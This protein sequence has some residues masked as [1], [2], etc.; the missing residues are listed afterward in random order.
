[1]PE[2]KIRGKTI[3]VTGAGGGLG[4]ALCQQLV[5]AGAQVVALDL[6]P[7][8]LQSLAN[9]VPEN[10]LTIQCDITDE[11]QCREATE[12]AGPV[13]ILINNAGI[14]HFSRFQDM[15]SATVRKVMG[16]NF[17]GA[18]NMTH[19]V[20]P[21]I[22]ERKGTIVAISSVAGF[23][24]LYGRSGYSASK[25][26]LHGF[27]DSLRSEVSEAGVEV[28]LVCPSFIASQQSNTSKAGE[29]ARPGSA[30]QTAGK[31]LDP[32][33]VAGVIVSGLTT[34]KRL[35][36]IGRISKLAWWV[37][38]MFPGIYEHLMRKKMKSEF[39]VT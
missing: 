37:H 18:V 31:P 27:F 35:L 39:G 25:H 16:V 2:S 30:S 11:D 33:V 20:L 17:F 10:L 24:P 19:A 1:M 22:I 34:H 15:E 28:M 26:A 6:D 29:T 12:T 5:K 7:D 21:S 38:K 9:Q 36:T 14:T 3:L 32:D 4:R 23:S 8:G 13:D